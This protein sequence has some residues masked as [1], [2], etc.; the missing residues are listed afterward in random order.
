MRPR[1]HCGPPWQVAHPALPNTARPAIASGTW[2]STGEI[3]ARMPNWTKALMASH[4]GTPREL[5]PLS[6]L[7]KEL[8]VDIRTLPARPSCIGGK[9]GIP[10]VQGRN[11]YP[12]PNFKPGLWSAPTFSSANSPRACSTPRTILKPPSAFVSFGRRDTFSAGPPPT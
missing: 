6:E 7:A 2:L 12:I 8:G 9:S 5:L 10:L 1:V 4:A 11:V 3:G